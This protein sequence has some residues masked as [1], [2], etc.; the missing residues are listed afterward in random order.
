MTI[1]EWL[2]TVRSYLHSTNITLT[3]QCHL[4][5]KK[6]FF[7][8]FLVLVWKKKFEYDPSN[9][10]CLAHP[11]I[12]LKKVKYDKRYSLGVIVVIGKDIWK[13]GKQHWNTFILEGKGKIC[14]A[15]GLLGWHL[16]TSEY[17][18]KEKSH[19]SV[20]NSYLKHFLFISKWSLR[21][22]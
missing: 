17:S 20:Y 13:S 15:L 1:I 19:F 16:S 21:S 2:C 7:N 8:V 18:W 12:L 4:M 5:S 10:K 14:F 22:L 3:L 11:N 9:W 6:Y